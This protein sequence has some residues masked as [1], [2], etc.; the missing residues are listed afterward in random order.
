LDRRQIFVN[1]VTA[2]ETGLTK[3]DGRMNAGRALETVQRVIA[4][5]TGQ[6]NVFDD[7]ASQI[8]HG[9]GG[10]VDG[11][12]GRLSAA[13]K[14]IAGLDREVRRMFDVMVLKSRTAV[15]LAGDDLRRKTETS[16]TNLATIGI[17]QLEIHGQ[18]E[19]IANLMLGILNEAASVTSEQRLN[20]LRNDF[21]GAA[22]L[23]QTEAAELPADDDTSAF[24]TVAKQ[25]L[26]FGGEGG[27]FDVRQTLLALGREGQRHLV[28]SFALS[29]ELR[30]SV[31]SV[32]D[33]ARS[34][35]N[36]S[37]EAAAIAIEGARLMMIAIAAVSMLAAVLILIFFINPK[38]IQ[39]IKA[40]THAMQRLASGDLSVMVP[41]ADRRDEIGAMA[42]AVEIFKRNALERQE[43]A[44]KEREQAKHQM[45]R[46]S[47]I[48]EITGRFDSIVTNKLANMTNA[49][50]SLHETSNALSANAEETE[51]RSVTV[52]AATEQAVGNVETVAAAGNQLSNSITEISRRVS[53]SA[54]I[55]SDAEREALGTNQKIESLAE[56]AR[57]ISE[58]T[59]LISGIA[60]QTNLLAL[61]AT[62]EAARAGEAGRGFA[63]VAN[64]V[65]ILATQTAKATGDIAGQIT[66]MQR[67]TGEAVAAIR[68]ITSTIVRINELS[69]AIASAVEE[70]GAATEE[71]VRNVDQAAQGTR[72]V[73]GNISDV[74]NAATETGRMA[75]T[76]FEAASGL[77]SESNTLRKEVET[78]LNEVKVA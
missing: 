68:G 24:L 17:R 75:T 77:Q 49:A 50:K 36:A 33:Q 60:A 46:Q 74:T 66:E 28:R 14:E 63:V 44:E 62:I 57:R 9:S 47:R 53:E 61:N 71:I 23:L 64:E 59:E 20:A 8:H 56:A 18:A 43:M 70:Q 34:D 65:K 2:A 37:G 51:R 29:E 55:T 45:I 16:L 26:A 41:A 6:Q 13:Q 12:S 31:G 19:A 30:N 4:L 48:T 42:N 54:R 67:S 10:T 15:V 35:S 52:L 39:P 72:A 25:L 58:V 27:I 21:T 78:F 3:L 5:G 1:A 22:T 38:L 76:V 73:A 7:R 40:M 32:V 11:S 69:T